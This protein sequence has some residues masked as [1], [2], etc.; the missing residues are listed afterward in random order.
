MKLL[1]TGATGSFGGALIRRLLAENR[2]EK[3]VA[4][5]RSEHRLAALAEA[6]EH[7]RELSLMVGD[8]R[9]AERVDEALVRIDTVAHAAALKRTDAINHD[10]W[11]IMRTNFEGT[12]NVVRAAIARH[13]PRVLI[14]SSDKASSP[15]TMYGVSKAAAEFY[16]THANTWGHPNVRIASVRWGNVMGSTGSVVHIWRRQVAR[17]EPMALTDE[18]MNRF[19]ITMPEAVSFALMALE[20]MHG[21]EILIPD[22][23]AARLVDLAEAL[24]PGHPVK[25]VGPRACGEKLTEALS[26][27]DET[28]RAA[29]VPELGYVMAPTIALWPYRPWH[30][31]AVRSAVRS[32][33]VRQLSVTELRA[34]LV[35]VGHEA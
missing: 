34:L 30:G 19:W 26:S 18:R 23:P 17:G 35:T 31:E 21:G 11:E 24:A 28:P 9:D 8:V 14:L 16:A 4:F 7:P 2:A 5:A 3:I 20:V 29:R 32:D 22:L 33:G 15:V 27:D 10:P 6:L 13:V 25:L 12:R 1:L